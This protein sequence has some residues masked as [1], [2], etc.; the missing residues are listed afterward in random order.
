MQAVDAGILVSFT[1]N[2]S[3]QVVVYW[4]GTFVH[5]QQN[6]LILFQTFYWNGC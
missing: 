1:A 3:N 5:A 6:T 2:C 4:D